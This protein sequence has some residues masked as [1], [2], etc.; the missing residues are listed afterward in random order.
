MPFAIVIA[1]FGYL[2]GSIPTGLVLTKFFSK[3]DPRQSG[4]KNIGAT[5]IYRTAGKKLGVLTLLGDLLKGAIPLGIAAASK[6]PDRWGIP[7]A[8]WMALVGLSPFLGHLFPVFLRFK[9]GKGVATALGIYLVVS[10]LAVL[11]DLFL[12]L[13]VVWKWRFISLASMLCSV[14]MPVLIALFATDS[15]FYVLMAVIIAA[16]ILYRHRSNITRLLAGTEN[17]WKA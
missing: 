15:L 6:L 5:N 12:F 11:V 9:G 7:A 8:F 3:G 4:S 13:G 1:L 16:L 14:T 17:R 10:P 2:L